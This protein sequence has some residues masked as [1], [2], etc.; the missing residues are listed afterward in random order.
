[1]SLTVD[2]FQDILPIVYSVHFSLVVILT[3]YIKKYILDSCS[4]RHKKV[5]DDLLTKL[6]IYLRTKPYTDI[7]GYD[8]EMPEVQPKKT[9]G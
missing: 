5:A 8:V 6:Q 1:M 7:S 2:F 3:T 9:S 4:G